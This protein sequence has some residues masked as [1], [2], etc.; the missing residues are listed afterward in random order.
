[1]TKHTEKPRDEQVENQTDG[2]EAEL[3]EDNLEEAA[4][5]VNCFPPP[6]SCF[7]PSG[8]STGPYF[9]DPPDPFE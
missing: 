9:P 6:D 3:T 1:M 5:G 4:G 2:Q 8:G 7:P